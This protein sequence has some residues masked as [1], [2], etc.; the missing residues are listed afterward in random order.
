MKVNVKE[1]RGC[2]NCGYPI[3]P[4]SPGAMIDKAGRVFCDVNCACDF[5]IDTMR[6]ARIKWDKDEEN[7]D[8]N[9]T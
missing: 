4:K 9:N 5:Y 8:D 3:H 2:V 6:L 7:T 1:T